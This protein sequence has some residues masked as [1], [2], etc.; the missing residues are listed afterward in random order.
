MVCGGFYAV[1][2]PGL[3]RQ[4]AQP[5]AGWTEVSRGDLITQRQEEPG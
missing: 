1:R 5:A 4:T 3:G 2:R